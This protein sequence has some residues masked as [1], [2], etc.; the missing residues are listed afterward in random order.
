MPRYTADA[1][2]MYQVRSVADI[3]TLPRTAWGIPQ[4]EGS[5]MYTCYCGDMHILLSLHDYS[6]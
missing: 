4:P 3:E 5:L 2:D 6:M 1:M